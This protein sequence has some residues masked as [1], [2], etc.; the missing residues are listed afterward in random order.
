M[1]GINS[2]G[3]RLLLLST[4]ALAIVSAIGCRGVGTAPTQAGT[5][6][7]QVSVASGTGSITSTPAGINCPSTCSA[8]YN[9]GTQ[10]TLTE[11]PAPGS[12]FNG[13][14]GAC[15][16][17]GATCTIMLNANQSASAAFGQQSGN[18]TLS[19]TANNTAP[20]QGT[21]A[22]SPA[23]I[24]CPGTCSAT[25]AV[26]TQVTL[27]ETPG[28]PS[29]FSM[30]TGWGGACS[31]TTA[32]CSLTLNAN[33]SVTAAF[34]P[35]LN[36]IIFFAQENR[37]FDHYFGE[38]RQYWA[39]NGYPDQAFDGLAQFNPPAG[40]APPPTN[41]PC[42][43][44]D[45]TSYCDADPNGTPV[46]SDHL[47]SVCIENPSPS[48]NESHVD[49]AYNDATGKNPAA[50]NGF[51]QTAANDA[52]QNQPPFMD[53]NGYRAMG[54]YDGGNPSDPNDP[55]DLNFYYFMASNFATSDRFFS[56]V[57]SRTEPNRM[58]LMAGTS[59]G[60]AYPLGGSNP[61]DQS[62]LTVP[63]IFEA[64]QNAGITWRIYIEP[65]PVAV[66]NC[67][68]E[69]SSPQCL[70]IDSGSYLQMFT[71]GKT[72]VNDPTLSQNLVPMSQF[73]TDAA[74]GT[75]PQVAWIESPTDAGLD[76]HPTVD[77]SA[78]ENIQKGASFS[79][80]LM[81]SLMQSQSWKD[82]VMVFTYDEAGGLYDHVSPQPMP[83]PDGIT[84][85]DLRPGDICTNGTGPTCDFVFTGYRIP[86]V[87]ISPFTKKNYVS[88]T[89][90]DSTSILKLIETRFN[91]PALTKRDAAQFDMTEFFDFVNIPWANPPTPPKQNMGGPC[92]L[93]PPPP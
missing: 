78:P 67:A 49:W 76:E 81:T 77:D 59:Q 86:L 15:S 18:V 79:Y 56:P 52:R 2:S 68:P 5:D 48:W 71:Y 10:V 8:T 34:N 11:T 42:S 65:S 66:G 29:T 55:G 54:Y 17:T 88:H 44:P 26:N 74:N 30:F 28:A 46:P 38:L 7:L 41:P 83:S 37:S 61:A 90:A 22:S 57:M 4:C 72:V 93:Q 19:V 63:P 69:D 16:G 80:G 13:W 31:G 50:L 75:L 51:V 25:F 6:T 47:P 14:G 87:V 35:A 89:V 23:G 33:Q 73:A 24:N 43:N 92:S 62:P 1:S 91:I 85:Q 20:A 36:H 40:S 45:P 53:T 64:L 9:N 82:S 39:D 21:V 32:T 60:H 58:Y 70:F 12:G 27:T 3:T 84:P